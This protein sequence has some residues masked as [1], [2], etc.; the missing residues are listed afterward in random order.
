M[1]VVD[2]GFSPTWGNLPWNIQQGNYKDFVDEADD[3]RRDDTG[4]GT[5]L[6]RLI[7]KIMPKVELHVAR[8]LRTGLLN[9]ESCELVEKASTKRSRISRLLCSPLINDQR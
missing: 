9:E 5:W 8:V 1:A 6:A 3:D 7:C 2:T 4:H